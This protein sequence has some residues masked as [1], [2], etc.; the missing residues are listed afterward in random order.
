[1]HCS[2]GGV[3]FSE[4]TLQIPHYAGC[5]TLPKHPLRQYPCQ[6]GSAQAQGASGRLCALA[7][8]RPGPLAAPGCASWQRPARNRGAQ[9]SVRPTWPLSAA[10]QEPEE[11]TRSPAPPTR[12]E[13]AGVVSNHCLRYLARWLWKISHGNQGTGPALG[14]CCS[15]NV[16]VPPDSHVK[17]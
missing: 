8:Q 3:T 17:S 12:G 5:L 1:M 2:W 9:L 16:C 15:L 11:P 13:L 14:W 7:P 4:D 10:L 6:S